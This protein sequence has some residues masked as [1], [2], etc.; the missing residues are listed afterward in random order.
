M[1]LSII[2]LLQIEI[3]AQ[4]G[5]EDSSR[6]FIVRVPAEKNGDATFPGL[7]GHTLLDKISEVTTFYFV[8]YVCT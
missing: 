4:T 1:N 7:E 3:L 6:V 8:R 5:S 2:Y